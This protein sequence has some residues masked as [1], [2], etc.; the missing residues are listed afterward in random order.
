[1]IWIWF[2]LDGTGIQASSDFHWFLGPMLMIAFAFLG[3]TLFLTILVSMLSNTFSM[4]VSNAVQEIQYRRTVLTFEGVKSDAIFAYMP[5]FNILALVV[6]LPLKVI[7]SPRRFHTVN[8]AVIRILNLPLLLAISWYERRT[9]WISERKRRTAARRAPMTINWRAPGG[10]RAA[11]LGLW[12][13]TM[14]FWDYFGRFSVHGDLQ[15][16][17]D[18][19]PPQSVLDAIAEE[20]DSEI[21]P[22][23]LGKALLADFKSQFTEPG[24]VSTDE[25]SSKNRQDQLD[26]TGTGGPSK[27]KATGP[28]SSFRR[29]ARRKD[30]K[31]SESLRHEFATSDEDDDSEREENRQ[32]RPRPTHQ[33]GTTE[34][35]PPPSS[36][37]QHQPTSHPRSSAATNR[38][39]RPKKRPERK[40]SIIDYGDGGDAVLYEANERLRRL[41]T[42]LSRVEEMLGQILEQGILANADADADQETG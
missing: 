8:V 38:G 22:D 15:A 16:V 4:I 20:D 23:G 42:G 33:P 36:N 3:N 25:D 26:G 37:H 12:G 39:A 13:R 18:H 1:M 6:M 10:P 34:H 21:A 24:T 17:F 31:S 11:G 14:C 32:T 19:E 28:P 40:D 29:R 5:P 7:L 27:S 30:S 2:G 35:Q 41:E 9:L